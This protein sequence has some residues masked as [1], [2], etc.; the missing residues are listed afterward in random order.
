MSMNG[1]HMISTK[2]KLA[3]AA[4]G[5]ADGAFRG[6]SLGYDTNSVTASEFAL[7][8]ALLERQL[9]NLERSPAEFAE[10]QSA[11]I[12]S[13]LG[14]SDAGKVEQIRQLIRQTYD[15]A[16][17]QGLDIPSKPA[18]ETE[19]WVLRRHQLDRSA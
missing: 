1:A 17:S 8:D 18:T 3:A 15:Q 4:Q 13:T 7:R 14:I 5:A 11:F 16:V 12:Q 19:S 9:N 6:K 2:L 10:F